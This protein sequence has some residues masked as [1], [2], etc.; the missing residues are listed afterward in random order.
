LGHKRTGLLEDLVGS[1]FSVSKLQIFT[2]EVEWAAGG[3]IMSNSSISVDF[4]FVSFLDFR[5]H[6]KILM[7][8]DTIS[9][10]L[11]DWPLVESKS[12]FDNDENQFVATKPTF[13]L[14]VCLLFGAQQ[15]QQYFFFFHNYWPF[16]DP[17]SHFS[18]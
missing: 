5:R 13:F 7:E 16:L 11:Q 1:K 6:F 14:T 8:L 18:R 3:L 4:I 12:T 17:S 9:I 10:K 2:F 15:F